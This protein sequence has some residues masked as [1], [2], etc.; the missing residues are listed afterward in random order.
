MFARFQKLLD[1]RE[2]KNEAWALEILEK[3]ETEEK[4][5]NKAMVDEFISCFKNETLTSGLT[6]N[7]Q[8]T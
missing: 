5:G 8:V 1:I 3:E 2:A 4:S 7:K 6:I